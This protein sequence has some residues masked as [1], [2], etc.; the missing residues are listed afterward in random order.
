[1]NYT[2]ITGATSGIGLALA[3]VF[4]KHKSNLVLVA[5]H[6]DKLKE[7]ASSLERE[8]GVS[9]H[10][11]PQDLSVPGAASQLYKHIEEQG[12]T[13]DVLVNNAG[14]AVHGE[15]ALV[16]LHDHLQTV[17]LNITALTELTYLVLPG[18]IELGE[19]KI[20]NISS[21]AA[22]QPGPLMSVYYAS[23]AY[24]LWFSE[25]LH[26]ELK[27]KGISVTCLCPGP[28]KTAFQD[29][30]EIG[31]SR[32]ITYSGM[33]QAGTVAQ[34]GF[35]ALM[36]NKAVV[37]PGFVNKLLAFGTRLFPRSAVVAMSRWALGSRENT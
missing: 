8:F 25:A 9:V 20:L 19:G 23:K 22:F 26:N 12:L 2:L 33:M 36:K 14:F 35:N 1:M 32:L 27:S 34:V 7:V 10:T 13:I 17:E 24:V 3:R 18:M 29:Y 21:T 28:T 6:E 16:S 30:S 31:H 15:F 5:R 37:V 11:F 4:A